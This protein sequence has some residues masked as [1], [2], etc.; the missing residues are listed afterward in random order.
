MTLFDFAVTTIFAREFL[1]GAIII[2]EY[3]TIVLQQK[4][5]D[6]QV[7]NDADSEESEQPEENVMNQDERGDRRKSRLSDDQRRK[8]RLIWLCAIIATV[9]ALAVIAAIAIPL[10]ILSSNFN[11]S[12]SKIIE[13]ISK[14]VAGICLLQLSL[15]IPKFLGLYLSCKPKKEGVEHEGLTTRE[16]K[17]NVTWNI[18]REVAE[19]GVFL[20]PFFL[21][22]ENL[23]SIPLSAV[24][25]S[26][27]GL[28]IG[29]GIYFANQTLKHNKLWLAIFA[30]LLLVFLSAGLLTGGV[31]NLEVELGSTKTIWELEGSFWD[32]NRL[33]MTVLKPFGYNDSR[34]V[35]EICTYW[36]WLC[37]SAFLHYRKYKRAPK[38]N[39]VETRLELSSNSEGDVAEMDEGDETNQQKDIEVEYGTEHKN[40][41]S[42]TAANTET[43]S[44]GESFSQ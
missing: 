29:L 5:Q 12:T 11:N 39:D 17:F 8:L 43:F 28:A 34:T 38:P 41:P 13:G 35:L 3:R 36:S 27:V 14:I 25:G 6:I 9:L 7:T 1:E 21:S 31:H 16:I 15:K 40:K 18:W 26:V 33:P 20:I 10:A 2:G 22:G 19:C 42:I 32:V 44:Q 24:I 30:V 23:K 37:L 4:S